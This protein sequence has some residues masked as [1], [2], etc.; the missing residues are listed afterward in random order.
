MM[1]IHVQCSVV[2]SLVVQHSVKSAANWLVDIGDDEKVTLNFIMPYFRLHTSNSTLDAAA[3]IAPH[4]LSI[5][6]QSVLSTIWFKI[7]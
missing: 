7:A 6:N 2:I 3:H 5:F 4:H 1:H